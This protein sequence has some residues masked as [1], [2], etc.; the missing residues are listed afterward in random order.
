MTDDYFESKHFLDKRTGEVHRKYFYKRKPCN[1]L[2]LTS[3]VAKQLAGYTLIEKDLRSCFA[4]LDEIGR[5]HDEQ[6]TNPNEHF[7]HAKNRENYNIIKGL[8]VAIL[9]FYGKC[10]TRCEGRR[11]KLERSKLAPEFYELHDECM[12]FRHNFAAHSGAEKLEVAKVVAAY[13]DPKKGKLI[14]RLYHELNQ[15]DLY[16]PSAGE[17]GVRDLIEH[18]HSIVSEKI[19][20]LAYKVQNEEAPVAIMKALHGT[21]G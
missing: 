14:I 9:T 19:E 20:S 15:P 1:R 21:A 6:P 16:W 8:F 2:V 17:M 4:W 13:P 12:S 3:N 11:V 5:R 7:A 18:V 10:F